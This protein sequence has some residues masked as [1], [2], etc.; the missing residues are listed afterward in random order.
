MLLS[1]LGIAQYTEHHPDRVRELLE[2]ERR[3]KP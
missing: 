3:V 2:E 1:F